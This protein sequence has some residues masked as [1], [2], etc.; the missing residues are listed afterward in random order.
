MPG[1]TPSLSR[2]DG[3]FVMRLAHFSAAPPIVNSAD[4][5]PNRHVQACRRVP[6]LP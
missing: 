6:S 4:F 1:L 2:R 3:G 5:P